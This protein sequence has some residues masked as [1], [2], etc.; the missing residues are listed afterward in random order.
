MNGKYY[1]EPINVMPGLQM[2]D[3]ALKTRA[4][5]AREEAKT[6]Q[7]EM[8]KAKAEE[9]E[10]QLRKQALDVYK[11]GDPN[12][13]IEFVSQNP[14]AEKI[15]DPLIKFKDE[16]TR[17]NMADTAMSALS[18][19]DPQ[20]R[21]NILLKR[22]EYLK[23]KGADFQGTL[24]IAMLSMKNPAEAKKRIEMGL[25]YVDKDLYKAYESSKEKPDSGQP[26][27]KG[28][29][30]RYRDPDG[31]ERVGALVF[32]PKTGGVRLESATVDGNM[33]SELGETGQ[34]QTQRKIGQK[35]G[36][37]IA[38]QEEQRVAKVIDD[39]VSA[40]EST[41][42]LRRGIELLDSVKTG[43]LYAASNAAQR[44]FGVQGADEGELSYNLSNAVLSR[45]RSTFGAQFTEREG[46]RL[47]RIAASFTKSAD[48]NKR[49]LRQ[50]LAM[51]ERKA[52]QAIRAAEKRG[53]KETVDEI[54]GWLDFTFEGND[55]INN[56]AS[57]EE[58]NQGPTLDEFLLKAQ[59]A[60]PGVSA[61][62][63]TDYYN[64]K[65][66]GR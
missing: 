40:A 52:A 64:Q 25:A 39:G 23:E 9:A 47:E 36:E 16:E 63:L 24:D 45:L 34:E 57:S 56:K 49:L 29:T 11:K 10:K 35:R 18:T 6:K 26:F 5:Y 53:D 43:G 66:G 58:S 22:A 3:Q 32:D 8:E 7:A 1:V 20:E 21:T 65:Y 27:Q 17:K 51:A 30:I 15:L 48:V 60:N 12:A 61:Q 4:S 33:V 62:E 38:A 2:L 59:E 50:A 46:A 41:A 14:G 54:Q 44:I 31:N 37:T 42:T 19:E 28:G 55:S 13:Y